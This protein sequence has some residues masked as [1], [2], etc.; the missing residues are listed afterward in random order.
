MGLAL[1]DHPVLDEDW[2]WHEDSD[3]EFAWNFGGGFKVY[4]TPN[5]AVRA[6]IRAYWI[7]TGEEDYWEDDCWDHH[8]D[9][10]YWEDSLDTTEVSA[11]FV[12]RF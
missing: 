7:N 4:F 3:A 6:D 5:F 12:V 9:C 1:L 10:D 2:G 8:D 11:G